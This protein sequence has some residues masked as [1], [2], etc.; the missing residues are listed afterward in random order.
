MVRGLK[1]PNNKKRAKKITIYN[2]PKKVYIPLSSNTTVLVKTD[3]YV[4]KGDIIARKRGNLKVPL[5]SSVS[6]YIKGF[7]EKQVCN[8][9]FVKCIIIENDFLERVSKKVEVVKQI[10]EYSKEEFI[11]KIRDAG[12][13]GLGGGGFPTHLKYEGKINT[14]IINAVEC[15]PFITSDQI[16]I[17]EKCEE[18]LEAIDAVLT[19]NDISEGII[20]VNKT[21]TEVIDILNTYIGTYIKIKLVLVPNVYPIG[22]E[23]SLIKYIKKVNYNKI[24]IEKGIAVNNVSTMF[25]IYEALKYSKPLIER[26]LTINNDEVKNLLVRIGTPINELI[27]NKNILIAGGPMMGGL[28]NDSL[29]V[30]PELTGIL[31]LNIPAEEENPCIRCGKCVEVCPAKLSPVLIM[32]N[33]DSENLKEFRPQNCVEC[34]LCSYICPAKINVR[35]YVKKAKENYN[36]K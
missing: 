10:N 4:C 5:H 22:W 29:V 18:I 25:A 17:K 32:E 35:E 20:A 13:V 36:E 16:L 14:L 23:R 11:A 28:I 31:S 12:I 19:I 15:E 8:G 33:L 30:S 21:N 2:K 9:K 26:V 27:K 24:P 34:G 7:K 1:I 6:G 3:D